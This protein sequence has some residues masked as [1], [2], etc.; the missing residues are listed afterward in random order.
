[1]KPQSQIS[2]PRSLIPLDSVIGSSVNGHGQEPSRAGLLPHLVDSGI[3][4]GLCFFNGDLTDG[5]KTGEIK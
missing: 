5:D 3:D 1:M 4:P 2:I